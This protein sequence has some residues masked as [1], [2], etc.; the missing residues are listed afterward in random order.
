MLTLTWALIP[1]LALTITA[2]SHSINRYGFTESF[3]LSVCSALILQRLFDWAADEGKD[4]TT[5]LH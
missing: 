4:S 1:A 3:N 2:T 5:S